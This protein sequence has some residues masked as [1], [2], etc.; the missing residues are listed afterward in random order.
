[1]AIGTYLDNFINHFYRKV[2]AGDSINKGSP[3]EQLA[4]GKYSKLDQKV[5]G[6]SIFKSATVV[7]SSSSPL[8]NNYFVINYTDA[9]NGLSKIGYFTGDSIEWMSDEIVFNDSNTSNITSSSL[10]DSYFVVSYKDEGNS[11]FGTSII[12]YFTGDS[13]EWKTGEIIFHGDSTLWITSSPLGDSYFV[14]SYKDDNSNYGYSRVGYFTGDTIEWISDEIVFNEANTLW[15][16]SSPLGLGD[17]YFVVS[18]SDAGASSHGT[19]IIGVFTGDSIEWMSGEIEFRSGGPATY[20]TSSPL[21]DSNFVVSY[22][23]GSNYGTS[24]IGVF[25]GD[26]IEWMSDEITFNSTNTQ[27]ISSSS[28]GDS[29]FAVFYADVLN[30]EYGT[31]SFGIFTGD[32]IEWISSEKIFHGD[33]TEHITSSPLGDSYFI[34][35]YRDKGNSYYGTA[36]ILKR[37]TRYIGIAGDSVINSGDSLYVYFNGIVPGYSDLTPGSTYYVDYDDGSLTTTNTGTKAGIAIG[38]TELLIRRV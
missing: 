23:G 20:I 31:Y 17:S 10:G 2:Y 16:T 30:A 25:T 11:E 9:S 28:L 3:V 38:D 24:R 36:R 7:Q 15:I 33:I 27:Y 1:M 5:G 29:F 34:V 18:Y 37:Y 26:S 6:E 14:V 8:S 21:G 12:G 4:T 32:S 35:S 13:I 19:S 22:R